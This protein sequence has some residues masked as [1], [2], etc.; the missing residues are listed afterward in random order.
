MRL[1]LLFVS[2]LTVVPPALCQ[3]YPFLPV[4]GPNAPQVVKNLFQDSRGRLWLGGPDLV[5]FD[6]TRFLSLRDYGFPAVESFEVS[7]DPS[8]AIWI[9]A[10]TGVYRFANGRVEKVAEGVVTSVIAAAPDL[11]VAA[12]GPL[13]RG[14]PL[15]ASLVRIRRTAGKW[16]SETVTGLDSPGP[17]TA[18]ATRVLLFPWP[19]HG[20]IEV[21]LE[22]I[23]QW[24]PGT[25]LPMKRMDTGGA[26]GNGN[27][28]VMRDRAGCLWWL[29]TRGDWYDCGDGTGN[30][31]AP[32]LGADVGGALHEGSDGSMVLAGGSILAVGRP[33]A[34]KIATRA[35]G[36]P[37]LADAL[38]AKDGTVWLGTDGGLYRFAS[39]FR[40][41][42]WTIREGLVTPPW[43]I[44]RA[45]NKTYAGLTNRIVALS[46]D[47]SRW[48]TLTTFAA[49]GYVAGLLGE[50]DGSLL[51]SFIDGGAAQVGPSGKVLA[52]ANRESIHSGMRLTSTD[53]GE[54]WL[55]GTHLGQLRR[56]GAE[57]KYE[58]HE[59]LTNPSGNVLGL[60]FDQ[61]RGLLWACY[62][63]GLVVRDKSGSWKE[64]TTNDGLA[65]NGCWSLAPL[66]NGDVWYAYYGL[67][68]IARIR[69]DENGHVTM[70]QYDR[71]SGIPEPGSAALDADRDGRLWRAGALGAYVAD[72]GEAE[73]GNWLKLSQADGFSANGMNTGS[74]FAD[75]DGSLWWGEDN[76]LA[77]YIP[78]DDLVRPKFAPAVFVSAFSW[79]G[80]A[81]RLAE[82]VEDLPSGSEVLVHIG[83]LQ[84]DRRNA[85]NLRYRLM[86][87][88]SAWQE[89]NNLDLPLGKLRWGAHTL[90]VQG[91]LFTGPWSETVSRTIAVRA[92]VWA[93]RPLL[94]TYATVGLAILALYY[95]FLRDRL[96]RSQTSLPDLAPWRVAVLLPEVQDLVGKRLDNRYEVRELMARG[97]FANVMDGY[98]GKKKRRCAIKIFR[99]EVGKNES[100]QKR[101]EQEVRVL[102]QVRHPHVVSIYAHGT[103]ASGTPYLVMEFVEGKSL[104]EVLNA[105]ALAPARA[106][107]L[108]RQLG[109][110][111]EAIHLK[112]ICHRDVKPENVMVRDPD[113]AGEEAVLID[114]SISLVKE[115]EE[116]LHGLSRA[117]G[118]FEYMAPEQA[119]GYAQPSSDI[120]SLAKLL[121]EMVTGQRLAALLPNASMDLPARVRELI[122]T[123]PIPFSET[124]VRLISGA[125]EFDPSH[126]PGNVAA[127]TAAIVRDLGIEQLK[128]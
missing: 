94:F 84:F 39:P 70:R 123:L 9:A 25:A 75:S 104:R 125:L 110:A 115:A 2:L 127:F 120:Y 7:E 114:F 98:D 57:L 85:L 107:R 73:A 56:A 90:E 87:E 13:G 88:K 86:P 30:H 103:I 50:K 128:I 10:E 6:G 96:L 71:N 3:Q 99:R 67:N 12:V 74:F 41:E 44:A 14:R 26:P 40:I 63:G 21:R 102:Q 100:M 11:V 72:A 124:S 122:R 28:K 118:T 78:A 92:P 46:E 126:R 105:G 18:D 81:P 34:F 17:L 32:F 117:A 58:K 29:S 4:T 95:F 5:C 60:K 16:E 33:G 116:T 15:N 79:N 68:A 62:N 36:L 108:L 113:K 66:G 42:N 53:N 93:S 1:R 80:S 121:I 61:Q 91:R 109:E 83:S 111:L 112:G 82:A 19:T 48:E 23:Q 8:G 77:H 27:M 59:L 43:S 38:P 47:R 20:W 106:A 51:A 119:I 101:F 65:V 54:I 89:T 37:G 24:S 69:F 76:D 64:L 52:Q 55:G 97:G 49:G 35:N 31:G 45:G 22:D